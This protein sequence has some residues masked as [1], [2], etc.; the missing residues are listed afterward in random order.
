MEHLEHVFKKKTGIFFYRWKLAAAHRVAVKQEAVGNSVAIKEV[1]RT[2]K[3]CK[4]EEIQLH[5]NPNMFNIARE[6]DPWKSWK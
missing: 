6:N 1:G 2:D 3:N 4:L 5:N